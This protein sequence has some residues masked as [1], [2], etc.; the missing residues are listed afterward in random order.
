MQMRRTNHR[1]FSVRQEGWLCFLGLY[2]FLLFVEKGVLVKLQVIPST[3]T[4]YMH[5]YE[6]IT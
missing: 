6:I 2:I 4:T 1:G 3:K 5:V